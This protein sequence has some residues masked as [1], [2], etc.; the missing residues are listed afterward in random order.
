VFH[1]AEEEPMAKRKT[2]EKPTLRKLQARARGALDNSIR[3]RRE[4]EKAAALLA[5]L[6]ADLK[7]AERAAIEADDELEE[8]KR[9]AKLAKRRPSAR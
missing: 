6:T 2:P 8:G 7:K 9:R 3:A 4:Q 5:F 1:L